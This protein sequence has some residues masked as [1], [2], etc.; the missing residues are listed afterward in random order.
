M[1]RLIKPRLWIEWDNNYRYVNET[2]YLISAVGSMRLAAPESSV[3]SPRGIVDEC[4]LI[5]DNKTGRYSPLNTSS[6]LYDVI[7]GGRAYHADMY[8]EVSIDG[9]ATYHRIF[10]GVIKIPEESG[11]TYREGAIA[12]IDCRSRDETLLSKRLSTTREQMVEAHEQFYTE[13]D[14][15]REWL[16][17]AALTE[18][19]D[20]VLDPGLWVIPWAWLDDESP[21]EE[22]WQLASA[23]GGRFYCDPDGVFRYENAQHWLTAPHTTSQAFYGIDSFEQSNPRFDDRELYKAVTVEIAER[24]E[25]EPETIW[26][27]DEVIVVPPDSSRTI[28]AKL[29][30]PATAITEVNYNAVTAGA[31]PIN[32]A[33]SVAVVPYAA[34]CEIT[35]TNSNDT[36]AAYVT[37]LNLYGRSL[38]GR[39][40]GEETRES[41]DSFW[42]KRQGRTKAL[43]GN[44]Y[45]QSRAQAAMLAE[46]L[47]D[48]YQLPRLFFFLRGVPGNPARRLGDRITVSDASVM[49]SSR[50]VFITEIRWRLD[51]KGFVQDIGCIDAVGLFPDQHYF[52][53][54]SSELG[55]S[56]ALF[57]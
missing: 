21:L 22:I 8:L 49:N 50:H 35:I 34:R 47:R 51:D 4:T 44:V 37:T 16:H 17:M 31:K 25:A 39:P 11:A 29:R 26:Q 9:G 46:F 2:P 52:T 32:N 55:G 45:I 13:S 30:Q 19:H 5:L 23:C 12:R 14:L 3:S 7:Q 1:P 10:T 24:V 56:H 42:N 33:V 57:Y 53:L 20:F 28:I 40:G 36:Y 27:A 48:R 38:D 43:R 41:S 54:G 6:P 18:G 15:M